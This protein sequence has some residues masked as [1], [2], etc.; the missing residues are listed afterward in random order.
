MTS[1]ELARAA[2]ELCPEERLKLAHF[3][4]ESVVAPQPLNAAVL[5]GIRRLEDL[6]AGRVQGLSERQYRAA[7]K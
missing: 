2:L 3:L 7:V 5:Q 6:L 4:L 1:T